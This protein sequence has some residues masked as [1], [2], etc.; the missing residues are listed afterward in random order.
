MRNGDIYMSLTGKQKGAQ[1]S[2]G[3][4]GLKIEFKNVAAPPPSE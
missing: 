3:G 2:A 1:I 4:G